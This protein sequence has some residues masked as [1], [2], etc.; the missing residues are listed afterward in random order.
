VDQSCQL[1]LVKL[2]LTNRQTTKDWSIERD[3]LSDK[4]QSLW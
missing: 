1:S 4:K 2:H 3:L